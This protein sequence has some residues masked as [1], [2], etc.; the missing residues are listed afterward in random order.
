MKKGIAMAL[1]LALL[2]SVALAQ[3]TSAPV[4]DA[5]PTQ[6]VPPPPAAQLKNDLDLTDEQVKKMRAIRDAGG[7]REE[8]Q[9]VLTPEQRAKQEELRKQH[10]GDRKERKSRMQEQM[11]FTDAQMKQMG[12]IRRKGGTREEMRAVMT[13]EQQAKFDARRGPHQGMSQKP[14][15]APARASSAPAT[16]AAPAPASNNAQAPATKPTE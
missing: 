14:S 11:G 6:K 13:P 5:K 12:E 16:K 10:R 4:G 8:M 1:G 15:Q 3:S 9:A 2:S 7:T